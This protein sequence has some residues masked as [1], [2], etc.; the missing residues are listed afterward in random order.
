M[1][2]EAD[3][4]EEDWKQSALALSLTKGESTTTQRKRRTVERR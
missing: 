2:Y 1:P 3:L 4:Y